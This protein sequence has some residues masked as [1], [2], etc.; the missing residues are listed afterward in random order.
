LIVKK[1][2]GYHSIQQATIYPEENCDTILIRCTGWMDG[3][4]SLRIQLLRI[5]DEHQFTHKMY[6]SPLLLQSLWTALRSIKDDKNFIKE[7]LMAFWSSLQNVHVEDPHPAIKSIICLQML[8]NSFIIVLKFM[9]RE[10][11]LTPLQV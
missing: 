5:K 1:E 4:C 6:N 10:T 3:W 9:N 7:W 11:S 2:S 8:R